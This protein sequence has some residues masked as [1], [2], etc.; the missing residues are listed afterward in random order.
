M[1]WAA[2]EE[3]GYIE[4]VIGTFMAIMYIYSCYWT[5]EAEQSRIQM[6]SRQKQRRI[7]IESLQKQR[8]IQM[9]TRQ[10]QRRIEMELFQKR[11]R[12]AI[13]VEE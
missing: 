13:I 6:E 10:K 2:P 5:L 11:Q 12:L 8:C 3:A 1:E 9:E 7:L 4:M